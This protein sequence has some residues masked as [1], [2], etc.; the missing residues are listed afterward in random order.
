MEVRRE[1]LRQTRVT[2]GAAPSFAAG[3]VLL[4]ID[5]F[6]LTTNNIT[7]GVVGDMIGYWG[8][9]PAADGWGR[10]PVWGFADV[11]AS[12]VD[13]IDVGARLFGYLPMSSHLIVEPTRL[14]PDGFT[15]GADHRAALPALY[16][17][18]VRTDADP[19]YRPASEDVHAILF[20][21]FATSFVI[22]DFL[23]DNR[24]F[25]AERVVISSA[26]SK[27][28][29]GT[30]LCISRRG[31][32]RPEVVGLTSP[33]HAAFVDGLGCYDAVLAYDDIDNLDPSMSTVF[34]DIAGNAAVRLAIH[35]HLGD[36]LTASHT[37][38]VTHWEAAA[39]PASLPGPTPTMFFAPAQVEKRIAEWGPAGYQERFGAA[40]SDLL[41]VVEDWITVSEVGGLDALQVI[42]R[43][44][45]DGAAKPDA[46]YLVR[47]DH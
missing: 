30:A 26:S 12:A 8:F 10:V 13:G 14:R 7:Y 31:G 34:V 19:V 46:G 43:H 29:A 45:V 20:P 6:G 22:D 44:M 36:R 16:N 3:Q 25:G 40:W 11:V 33:P 27:T 42:W 2:S 18:Y 23:A 32:T 15:D 28:A 47:L 35:E 37:V 17:R 1:D 39:P 9:F 41:D 24:D 5:R 4:R 38:G 21:L